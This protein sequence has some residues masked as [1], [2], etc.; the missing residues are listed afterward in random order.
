MIV[1]TCANLTPGAVAK[2]TADTVS[3][4]DAARDRLHNSGSRWERRCIP[5]LTVYRKKAAYG[6]S[7]DLQL[8]TPDPAC[9][10]ACSAGVPSDASCPPAPSP[11]RRTKDTVI[12]ELEA[13]LGHGAVV[14]L[15]Y[16]PD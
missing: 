4:A 1:T 9:G 16:Y 5:R 3:G 6:P 12:L 8:D 2:G 11:F 15:T 7:P 10:H 14:R 13:R